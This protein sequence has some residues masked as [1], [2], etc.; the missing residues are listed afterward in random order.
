MAKDNKNIQIIEDTFYNNIK[1]ILKTARN[2]AYKQINFIM[3]EAYW[4]IGERIVNQEQNGEDKANSHTLC[5]QLSWSHYRLII[6][7]KDDKSR[8]LYTV[9]KY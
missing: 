9:V 1:N 7:L 2:K 3:V 5:D 6:R 8:L 4:N